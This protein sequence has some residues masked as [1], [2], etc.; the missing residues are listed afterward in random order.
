MMDGDEHGRNNE[1]A[2][3]GHGFMMYQFGSSEI[4]SNVC[5]E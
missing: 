3:N 4:A 1:L 5:Y 2:W